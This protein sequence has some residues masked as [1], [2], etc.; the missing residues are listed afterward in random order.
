ML[1]RLSNTSIQPIVDGDTLKWAVG[2]S[3]NNSLIWYTVNIN[4][5]DAINSIVGDADCNGSVNIAD[6]VMLQKWLLGSGT[7]INWRNV[8]LYKDNRIDAF[9]MIEMRKLIANK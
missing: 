5:F 1:T 2:D 9:D 3:L 7:L 6:A 4:E 8:D